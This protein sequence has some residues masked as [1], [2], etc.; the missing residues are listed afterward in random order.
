MIDVGTREAFIQAH[1]YDG[2][3]NWISSNDTRINHD[4]FIKN[5]VILD[6]CKIGDNVMIENSIIS[7]NSKIESGS[8]IKNEIVR[9]N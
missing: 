8:I 5:S 7:N 4:S 2:E 9:T 3:E 6:G 1:I